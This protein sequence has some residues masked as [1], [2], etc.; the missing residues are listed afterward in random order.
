MGASRSTLLKTVV[1]A[2]CPWVHIHTHRG[3]TAPDQVNRSGAVR[4]PGPGAVCG[5]RVSAGVRSGW[6]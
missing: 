1:A 3:R 5:G 6:R 4:M 2:M